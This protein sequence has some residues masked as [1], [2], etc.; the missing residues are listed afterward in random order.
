MPGAMKEHTARSAAR[1]TA[2]LSFHLS[3]HG[4]LTASRCARNLV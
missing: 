4:I 2:A 1:L 3:N